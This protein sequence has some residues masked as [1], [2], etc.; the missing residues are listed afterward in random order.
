VK[1]HDFLFVRLAASEAGRSEM[2]YC[3]FGNENLKN[4]IERFVKDLRDLN[5]TVG[6]LLQAV[7]LY[8]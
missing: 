1:F 4:R 5:A 6:T 8:Q 3:T 7:L 2:V